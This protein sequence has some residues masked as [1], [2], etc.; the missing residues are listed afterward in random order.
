MIIPGSLRLAMATWAPRLLRNSAMQRPSPV[1]PPVMKADLPL[2]VPG[3]NIGFFM[4]V[5]CLA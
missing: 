1:P 2:K 3:G 5:K 4:A